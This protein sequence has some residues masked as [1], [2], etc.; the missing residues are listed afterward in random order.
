ML[1]RMNTTKN[2]NADGILI[3]AGDAGCTVHAELTG[4]SHIPIRLNCTTP[5]DTWVGIDLTADQA[6]RMAADLVAFAERA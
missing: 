2:A 6:R 1:S 3:A 5:W 4:N